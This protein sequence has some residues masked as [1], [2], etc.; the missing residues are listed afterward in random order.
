MRGQVLTVRLLTYA[1]AHLHLEESDVIYLRNVLLSEFGCT[2]PYD[3]EGDAV[4]IEEMEVPDILADEVKTYAMENG[5]CT[6]ETAARYVADIFGLLSPLPSAV[7]RTFRAIRETDGAQA[8]CDY[9]YD[10]C[11][12]NG[13]I[14][15]TAIAR[16]L[17]W[18]FSDGE[19]RLEITVNLS[20]PEKN[21]R[22]IAKL[23]TAPQSKKYPACALCKENE[24]FE[25]TATHPP[26]RNLRTVK[27]TV[28]GERWFLQYSPYAY[29]DEHCIVINEQHTPMK[30]DAHT[31]GKLLDFVDFLPN[32]FIGSNASL[33]I[34]GGSILNHEHFQGGLHL[35]PMHYAKIARAYISPE[36]P[37]LNIGILDWYNSAVQCEGK[38][39][40]AVEAFAAKVIEAWRNYDDPACEILSHTGET[41]HNTV[42]PI[43]RKTERGYIFTMILRNNRTSE[44]YPNG[45]FHVHPEY[46]NIKS[47]GIGLIEA[48][49]LFIL[50]PRL[51]RQ[52]AEMETILTGET[53]YAP[54][55]I[56]DPANDLYV[57]RN[58]L[59]TLMA[60]GLAHD[61]SEAEER[62][63]AY[64]NRVCAGIL[65]NT[66]VFKHDAT[67]DAGFAAFLRTLGLEEKRV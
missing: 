25:G 49:G 23:L 46:E 15:K 2:E 14:Q 40:A 35:M 7:N 30:V 24:G 16:N 64:V 44:T 9:L 27:L 62:V 56:E 34:V 3:G 43:C 53:P 5:L 50:P 33:P 6:E 41:P 65:E 37:T 10:L 66:A 19:R 28:G 60:G 38:D 26:R 63:R 54:A 22:D 20:K 45:I 11:V 59:G 36:F 1:R 42:S 18:D 8:A 67:G 47:E 51:K 12:K 29:Y 32:Y 4:E 39:R 61:R 17:K 13:Y 55:K 52:F 58:M 21:N 57:H 31:P 48:M